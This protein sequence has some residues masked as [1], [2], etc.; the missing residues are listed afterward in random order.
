MPIHDI[1]TVMYIQHIQGLFQSWL[2]IAD[3]ALLI[4]AQATTAV[5]LPERL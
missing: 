1:I 5:S 2:S 3:Y 4:V